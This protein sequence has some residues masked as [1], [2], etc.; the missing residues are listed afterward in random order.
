MKWMI[1][2]MLALALSTVQ[3][4]EVD[5]GK[6]LFEARCGVCHQL[7]EPDMLNAKQWRFVL[8]TMQARMRQSGM[9]PL[10]EQEMAQVEGYLRT[11]D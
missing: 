6:A 9:E 10:T 8:Q 3:A 1:G 4:D 5:E 7:P 2:S 11:E